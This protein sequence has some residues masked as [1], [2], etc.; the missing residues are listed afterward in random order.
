M[1][2]GRHKETDR[3]YTCL[4]IKNG[5]V[6]GPCS[7]DVVLFYVLQLFKK[8]HDFKFWMPKVNCRQNSLRKHCF[9][10]K[11]EEKTK[12]KQ[13]S[14]KTKLNIKLDQIVPPVKFCTPYLLQL[15]FF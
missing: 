11:K 13:R 3:E 1:E 6:N 7:L 8:K 14:S 12:T 15:Y 5:N 9:A 2:Y 4:V 10:K